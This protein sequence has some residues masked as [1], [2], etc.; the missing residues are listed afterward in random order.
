MTPIR[1]ASALAL[2]EEWLLVLEAEGFAP[3]MR[4][5][6]DEFVLFVPSGDAH[7]AVQA[8]WAYEREN[9][10]APAQ[11]APEWPGP[12]PILAAMSIAGAIVLFFIVCTMTE[13]AFHWY[14]RGRASAGL[15]LRGELWRTV[16]ALTLHADFAHAIS[17]AIAA[18]FFVTLAGT[19]MGPGVGAALI[20]AAGA[21][22]NLLNAV[23]H[24]SM[25]TSVGASTAIFGAIG[26][27]GGLGF[28]RRRRETPRRR[29]WL[30]LAA[31]VALLAMIGT[32]GPRVDL[33]AHFWGLLIGAAVG[34]RL[35]VCTERP[36]PFAAQWKCGITAM[37]VILV[38]WMMAFG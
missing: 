3:E 29:T 16:T 8:L 25:H 7:R 20:L 32:S 37:V 13:A 31:S 1:T 23:F 9:R 35:A 21:S 27:L 18:A 6:G 38:S 17:N 30:P 28:A 4:T 14:D 34:F 36:L 15:I 12:G 22:G 26:L 19:V 33:W 5:L 11:K 24:G 2:A 10:T